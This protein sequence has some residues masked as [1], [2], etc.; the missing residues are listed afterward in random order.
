MNNHFIRSATERYRALKIRG[1]FTLA[2]GAVFLFLGV[3]SATILISRLQYFTEFR[4]QNLI[5]GQLTELADDIRYYDATLTDAVRAYL[6]DPEDQGAYDRYYADAAALDQAIQQAKQLATSETDRM[7]FDEIDRVN[8]EL[9]AIEESL[10]AD[11][12]IETAVELYRGRYGELKAEY[13][14]YVQ[15]FAERQRVLLDDGQAGLVRI[16]QQ[17]FVVILGVAFVLLVLLTALSA[18][19]SRYF[20]TRIEALKTVTEQFAQGDLGKRIPVTSQDE[21]GDLAVAFN[22]MAAQQQEQIRQIDMAR[23]EAVEATRMK[24]LFLATMSH[25]LRTPLNAMIGFLHLM[26]YSGQM[27]DDNEHMAERALANTQRLLTLI[28]N[29]LD[30]SRIATGGLEIVPGEMRLPYVASGLYNDLKN[31]ATDKD[32]R[33]ELDVDPKLPETINHDEARISQIVTNLVSNAIKF[34]ESGTVRLS[35]RGSDDRL[36]I[37]VSDTGIGIPQSKQHLIFDDFFQVDGTSTRHQQGAGLGLAIVKRLVLLMNGSIKLTSEVDKGST[38]TI[39]LPLNLP[40]YEPGARRKQAEHV[41]VS[42]MKTP[43]LESSTA[44]PGAA[45]A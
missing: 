14:S 17:T 32:L 23:R 33:L 30:L 18:A 12:S 10:L 29:I 26:I 45:K 1:K 16:I 27:D 4:S 44:Q 5:Q 28:N 9:V 11:P 42:S 24:D 20:I 21:L 39:D 2:F 3:F 22:T 43:T 6:I 37:Q 15:T 8:L 36:I 25:E 31:M 35:F 7:L 19:L 41:F 13:A 38:F 40:R 34:T